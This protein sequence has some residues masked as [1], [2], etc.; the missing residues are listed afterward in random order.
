M[1]GFSIIGGYWWRRHFHAVCVSGFSALLDLYVG[2]CQA[3]LSSEFQNYAL[4]TKFI[5]AVGIL[6][7]MK[8]HYS[9]AEIIS[10]LTVHSHLHKETTFPVQTLRFNFT[11]I[12]CP[13]FGKGI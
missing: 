8:H 2:G 7:K 11:G 6:R 13:N 3:A 4:N 10:K 9:K 5:D 12:I 1:F